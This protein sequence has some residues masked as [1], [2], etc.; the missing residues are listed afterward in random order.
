MGIRFLH[1]TLAFF[2]FVSTTGLTI[3]SHF[4]TGKYKYSAL[5]VEPA[6][7]CAKVQGHYPTEGSCEDEV[8]QT[9][10]CQNKASFFK[11]NHN[12]NFTDN[13][14]QEVEF[15]T[16]KIIPSPIN[17]LTTTKYQWLDIDYLNYKPPLIS[18]DVSILFQI[19]LC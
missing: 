4:C 2:L 6:N 10:C 17:L 19:F 11:S 18:K 3:N 16:F 7:C 12:Q 14:V 13:S 1:I 15:P 8:N 5:F 9:P